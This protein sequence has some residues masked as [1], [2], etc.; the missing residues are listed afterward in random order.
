[1]VILAALFGLVANRYVAGRISRRAFYGLAAAFLGV[2]AGMWIANR[3]M[4]PELVTTWHFL[5]CAILAALAC[6]LFAFALENRAWTLPKFAGWLGRRSYPIYLVHPFVLVLLAPLDWPWWAALPIIF[7]ATLLFADV[8]HR[9]VEN[10][11]VALGKWLEGSRKLAPVTLPFPAD[12]RRA[13]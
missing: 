1:L 3:L 6:S 11:G 5:R 10:P 2:V 4:F 12:V 7:G 9:L 13:A 8:I